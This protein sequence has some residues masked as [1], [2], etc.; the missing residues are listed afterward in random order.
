MEVIV[1]ASRKG[2]SGKST[3]TA[4][5]AAHAHKPSRPCLLI[6]TDPQGSLALWHRLRLA[7]GGTDD[8]PIKSAQRNIA[9]VVKQ[10]KQDG[11][12]WV[13]IDT[14]PNLSASVTDAIR[15]ATLVVIPCRPGVF[16]LDA[17]KDTIEFAREARRPYAVVINAAPPKRQD[18]ESPTVTH[19]RETL[20]ALQIPVWGGQITQRANFSAAL[21]EGEG[22]KEY[23][24]GSTAAAEIAR[25]WL[26]VEKS[27]KAIRGAR[28][29]GMHSVAA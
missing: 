21:A 3:L 5:L 29:G 4:H 14:A 2:G 12:E 18:V 13:F 22:A 17:V 7:G 20:D 9:D 10:A 6:D 15:A 16:D 1:F 28:E 27:V 11:V 26:A 23:D 8:L 25:L 19:A 24:S